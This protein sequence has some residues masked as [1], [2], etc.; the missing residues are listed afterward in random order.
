MQI[1][2][3]NTSEAFDAWA[4]EIVAQT[5]FAL[6]EKMHQGTYYNRDYI[7]SAVYAGAWEGKPAVLKLYDDTRLTNE[8]LALET[9]NR[10][11]Q[12]NVLRAPAVYR[13][14]V[15]TP[16]R[17]W[18]I[19]ERLPEGG[20]FFQSPL[21]KPEKATFVQL[22]V[23]YRK[24]FPTL[25]TRP[26]TLAEHLPAVE[27]HRTRIA[28]W[29][30]LANDKEEERAMKGQSPLLP[31]A[32][33]LSRYL[34]ALAAI[35]KEFSTR[36]MVWCHGHFKPNELYGTQDERYYLMNFA[37]TKMFPEGYEVAFIVWADC[38]MIG[39]W[40]VPYERWRQDIEEW[41]MLFEAQ[42]EALGIKRFD[43]LWRASL[44]ERCIGTI[45]A[46]FTASDLPR[47]EQEARISYVYRLLDEL[48]SV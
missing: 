38:L 36:R 45:L 22:Y 6:H 21:S 8:P 29:L 31:P 39:D 48:L 11:N 17:G 28:Q 47:E 14:S 4:K 33:F 12:S 16:K 46:D 37:H 23:E 24:L 41:K 1:P 10:N 13:F 2:P 34:K 25:P 20:S 27:Y 42:K 5:G 26:L 18:F 40:K 9:F 30:R 19:M 43:D 15:E 44:L 3:S 7:R 32:E 35:T